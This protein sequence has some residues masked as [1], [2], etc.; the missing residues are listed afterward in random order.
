MR[1]RGSV[2][3]DE[4]TL[5]H[6]YA[7]AQYRV[8]R[9][10]DGKFGVEVTAAGVLPA[11]ISGFATQEAVDQWVASHKETVK[12]QRSPTSRATYRRTFR[13]GPV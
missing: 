3:L 5:G 7:N 2:D 11:K 8:Y 12:T 4:E 10:D 1:R 13:K 6:P 9:L